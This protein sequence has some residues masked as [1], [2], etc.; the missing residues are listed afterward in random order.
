MTIST[1]YI[2]QFLSVIPALWIDVALLEE[3]AS[4]SQIQSRGRSSC[5][6]GG[7]TILRGSTASM[8]EGNAAAAKVTMDERRGGPFRS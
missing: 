8:P 4:S 2:V 6:S 7:H 1:G 5:M 3:E